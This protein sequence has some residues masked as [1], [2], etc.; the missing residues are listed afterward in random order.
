MEVDCTLI[1]SRT[2]ELAVAGQLDGRL[3][4]KFSLRFLNVLLD[5]YL[6]AVSPDSNNSDSHLQKALEVSIQS[7]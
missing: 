5:I 6:Y 7:A 4:Y 1:V 2:K 3:M